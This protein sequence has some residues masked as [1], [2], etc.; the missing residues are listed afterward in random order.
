[1]EVFRSTDGAT[2][3]PL[4][5]LPTGTTTYG[6]TG[7]SA[8]IKYYYYVDAV[9][10]VGNSAN[11]N[12][13]F[14]TTQPAGVA[15]PDVYLSNLPFVGTPINGWGPV[16][17]NVTVGAGNGNPANSNPLTLKGVVY[18]EGLGVHA[19]SSVTFALNNQYSTF[20][21]NIGIDDEVAQN[22]GSVYF[23][24]WGDGVE[25]YTSPLV[26]ARTA[27]IALDV[28]VTGVEQLTLIVVQGGS[29]N[30]NDHADWADAKL[31]PLS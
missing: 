16:M 18:P 19:Y 23:Q 17:R 3:A 9:N 8:S 12:T 2:F 26:T 14:A 1:M 28:D 31:V 20:E 27:T 6:D 10:G 15:Q 5:T 24:V 30:A 25:L 11:S 13:A 21:S 29:T 7:L 4:V 22:N